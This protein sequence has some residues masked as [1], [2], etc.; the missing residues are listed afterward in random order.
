M[1]L[2]VL[3]KAGHSVPEQVPKIVIDP[4][5]TG[6]ERFDSTRPDRNGV[7]I[8]NGQVGKNVALQ[9]KIG[10]EI[11]PVRIVAHY[12]AAN[13]QENRP[14]KNEKQRAEQ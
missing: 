5:K 14:M 2:D 8:P 11:L 12:N 13:G 3:Q 10:L 1:Q 6:I 4:N 7:K 9:L